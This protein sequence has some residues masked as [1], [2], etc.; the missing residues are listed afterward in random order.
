MI[1]DT[2]IAI[3]GAGCAGLSLAVALD[4]ARTPGHVLLL[5]PRTAYTR[6]RTWC[7]W[8]TEEHP[9]T[10]AISHSW[11]SWRVSQGA[12]AA[13]QSSR[14]YQYCHIPGDAFYR[15]AIGQ[16]ERAPEQELCPGIT[17]HSVQPQ[18]NGC[19]AVETSNGRLLANYVFDGRPQASVSTR[20]VLLQR[21]LGWHV[22][23]ATPCF[24]GK[25]VELMRFLPADAPGR[26]RFLYLLPF[27]QT[28]ALVEMTYLDDP[29][30]P[31]PDYERDLTEWLAEHVGEWTVLHSERGALS[32]GGAELQGVAEQGICAIG[33]RGGRIKPSSGYAFLRIQ[34]HSRAI[35]EALRDGRPVPTGAEPKLYEAMDSVFLRALRR[36]SREAPE[37]FLR[38][39]AGA[40]PD[41]LVR[42]LGEAS[43][44]AEMLQVALALPKLP[45]VRAGFASILE[46]MHHRLWSE[47]LNRASI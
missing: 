24:D 38:M 28:E 9:F 8:N 25:T 6:D 33:A 36:S 41:A 21:F 30:L 3:L 19:I 14:R 17:V 26:I 7:F 13:V 46:T 40:A 47:K 23:A 35:A 4:R 27:S 43:P 2:E 37:L 1:P 5:E 18:P 16:V 12:A 31:E 20:A 15:A 32:M 10:S 44:P 34:R 42:F 22:Q 45:L 39:F 11:Q 29:A